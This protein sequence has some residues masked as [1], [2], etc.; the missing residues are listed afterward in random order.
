MEEN[1]AKI[2]DGNQEVHPKELVEKTEKSL[3][4]NS[5]HVD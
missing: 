5:G 3:D 2:A 1:H 4:L